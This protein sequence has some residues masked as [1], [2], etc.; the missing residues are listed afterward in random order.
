MSAFLAPIAITTPPLRYK[1]AKQCIYCG[2]KAKKLTKEHIIAHAFA[3]DSL[4]L[5]SASCGKCQ[6]KTRDWETYCS[7]H[8][9]WPFRTR[10]GAPSSGKQPPSSFEVKHIRVRSITEDSHIDYG[11]LGTTKVAP[12]E[13]PFSFIALAF[14]PPGALIG[15]APN[16]SIQYR[17]DC[18][19]SEEEFRRFAP[20]SGDG[21]RIAPMDLEKYCRMLC[22]VAHAYAVAELGQDAFHPALTDF[23]R[24]SPLHNCWHWIGG[25]WD[26]PPPSPSFHEIAWEIIAHDS[27]WFV[28]VDI[29]LFAFI[30]SPQYR[31]VVGELARPV[32][33]FALLKQP[34]YRI[35][36]EAPPP[37]GEFIPSDQI[38]RTARA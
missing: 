6:E 14:P 33:Q 29:R 30:G 13:F 24:G 19:I 36:I 12:M 8:L 28:A 18:K 3:G 11:Q 2:A 25:E 21:F 10:V 27:R 31:I 22:K 20:N 35:E 34:L 15:R 38:I 1:P 4:I 5:P 9:W 26:N 32:D 16:A 37:I 17:V 23:I 7:R